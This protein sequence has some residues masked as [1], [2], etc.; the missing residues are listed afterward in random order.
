VEFAYDNFLQQQD[1]DLGWIRHVMRRPSL[2][3]QRGEKP[4]PAWVPWVIAD[5]VGEPDGERGQLAYYAH[6]TVQ[7]TARYRRTSQLGRLS[8]WTGIGLAFLLFLLGG[9]ANAGTRQLLLILMG[10]LPLIA[11]IWDAY[12]HKRA[13]KELIKQYSFMGR[14]FSKARK[15]LNGSPEIEFQRRVLRAL[16]Q[17]AL[18]EGAEWLLMHR[19]RPLEHG[20]L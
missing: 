15:L 10:V 20:R 9:E 2:Y 6:K 7:N 18:D 4:D 3:R 17:A 13:E 5:W 16:G 19:E 11:G 8:L 12:S 14:V 1:V